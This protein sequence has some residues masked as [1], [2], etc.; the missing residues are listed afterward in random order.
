MWKAAAREGRRTAGR[1]ARRAGSEADTTSDRGLAVYGMGTFVE[2]RMASLGRIACVCENVLTQ[3][4]C[5]MRYVHEMQLPQNYAGLL[6]F[7]RK[8]A[9]ATRKRRVLC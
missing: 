9:A 3:Q 4:C 7:T 1:S 5:C 8:S 2:R 6:T